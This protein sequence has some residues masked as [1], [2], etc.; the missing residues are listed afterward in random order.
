MKALETV[1]Y[2]E[3]RKKS[4]N[5]LDGLAV[6]MDIQNGCICFKTALVESVLELLK[7]ESFNEFNTNSQLHI[8]AFETYIC[9]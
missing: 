8:K 5:I 2:I 3:I 7:T 9:V 1:G 4:I 6:H